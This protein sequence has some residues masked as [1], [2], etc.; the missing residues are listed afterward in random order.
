MGPNDSRALQVYLRT[1][2]SVSATAGPT[3]ATY[4]CP[5]TAGVSSRSQDQARTIAFGDQKG[6]P[7]WQD[8]PEIPLHAAPDYRCAGRTEPASVEQQRLLA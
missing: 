8:V 5:S 4:G 3:S 7:V 6:R 2:V 1:A